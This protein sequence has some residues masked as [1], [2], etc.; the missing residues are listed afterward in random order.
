MNPCKCGGDRK[1]VKNEM[2][3]NRLIAYFVCEK[4]GRKSREVTIIDFV[5][6]QNFHIGG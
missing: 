5:E 3:V 1:F 2:K 4:C 6:A